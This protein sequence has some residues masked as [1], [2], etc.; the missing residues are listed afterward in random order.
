MGAWNDLI[1]R[2][3]RCRVC[4]SESPGAHP[5]SRPLFMRG[6]PT[7]AEV[8]F[9]AEAPNWDDT[10]DPEK[11]YL[12]V[13]RETDPSGR[14]FRELCTVELG[15]SVESVAI[16]N[17][18]LCLPERANG[19]HKV[20]AP[21]IRACSGHLQAQI[22][23]LDPLVVAPMGLVALD[24]LR[25]IQDHGFRKLGSAVGR[26]AAWNGRILFPLAHPSRL[27]RVNRA[28]AEQRRD[29]QELR[30]VLE[31]ARLQRCK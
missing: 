15:K 16:T 18:V 29:W 12:T 2:I 3:A 7:G 24:A 22:D 31:R 10:F 14:F 13:D 1:E 5:G 11:G 28:E 30:A 21:L 6:G 26:D 9:V 8:L 27:G 4:H 19:K 17:S 23:V 20:R 25:R